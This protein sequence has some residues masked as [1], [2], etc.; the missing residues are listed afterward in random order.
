MR[1][2]LSAL[3]LLL[4]GLVPATLHAAPPPTYG[5]IDART[6]VAGSYVGARYYASGNGRF[7]TVDPGLDL[8]QALVD[9][10][11]WNRYTYALNNPLKFT[12]PDGKNP[13][14][15]AAAIAWGLYEVGST[16]YDA[17][18]TYKTLRDPNAS[19]T[20]KQLTTG[21]FVAG[22]LPG[23]PG[24]G[25]TA[26]RALGDVASFSE[27]NFRRNVI[28]L[29]GEAPNATAEAHHIFPQA[30]EFARNFNRAGIDVHDP[31][32]GA[33]WTRPNHQQKAKEYNDRWRDFFGSR[34]NPTRNEI[35]DFGR[36]L[37]KEY[38]LEV[39]F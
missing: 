11:R 1:R 18:T 37:A 15:A 17:Y 29:L 8:E 27:G 14:L 24:G 26:G 39:P 4:V 13:I 32:F 21:L 2:V 9:P 5:A 12:D 25:A 35:L 30:G 33:W 38:G 23:V 36:Q 3:L 20:E 28:R 16:I 10:Q 34:R 6:H 31:K 22:I 7:T 19:T